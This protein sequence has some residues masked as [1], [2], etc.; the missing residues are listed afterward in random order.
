M[1]SDLMLSVQNL[2]CSQAERVLCKN[3]SFELKATSAMR[4]QGR[5]GCGKSTLLKTIAGIIQPHSGSVR[6]DAA[7]LYAGHANN[8]HPALTPVQNLLFINGLHQN[9][10]ETKV[11]ELLTI[12]GLQQYL[13]VAC[14]E[15]SAGQA[16]RILLVRLLLSSQKIWL[17]DEPHINLD[18]EAQRQ[19]HEICKRHLQQNGVIIVAAHRELDFCTTTLQL[20]DYV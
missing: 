13:T 6:H 11:I 3:L 10:S 4:I 15:L 5:N 2:A 17:L 1:P 7:I 14:E 20:E 9:T 12:V 16:Q 19:L 8:L 18:V